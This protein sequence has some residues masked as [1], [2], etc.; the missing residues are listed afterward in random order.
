MKGYFYI[1]LPI[2]L[3]LSVLLTLNVFFQQS[4]Q[5]EV[6]EQFN[7][8]QAFSAEVAASQLKTNL[9]VLSEELEF[10]SSTFAYSTN[11]EAFVKNVLS[12]TDK[13]ALRSDFGTIIDGRLKNYSGQMHQLN[14]SEINTIVTQA[15][16]K[17]SSRVFIV[18]TPISLYLVSKAPQLHKGV[19]FFYR[20]NISDFIKHTFE[21]LKVSNKGYV[22]VIN[23]QGTLLFHPIQPNMV[24]GNI[25]SPDTRCFNCHRDFIFQK[26]LIDSTTAKPDRYE[27]PS[28]Q[29]K[30]IA[31]ARLNY[32]ELSWII[33]FS[34]PYSEVTNTT[35]QSM[36]LYSYLIISI[37]IATCIISVMLIV[38]S[39]RNIEAQELAKRQKALQ[40]YANELEL[41]V[42]QRTAELVS[43]KEKLNT[44]VSAIGCGIIMIDRNA[45]II[46]TNEKMKEIA[47]GDIVGKYCEE[48]LGECLVSSFQKSHDTHTLDT[49]IVT[50]VFEKNRFY[51]ITTA[52]IWSENNELHGY[53]RLVQDITEIKNMENQIVHSEKLS[54]IG[55]LAAGIA[56][57]IGNPLTSIFSFVQILRENE[58]DPLKKENLDIIYNHINRISEI[59]KQLSGFTKMP[60]EHQLNPC[61][62]N[63]VIDSTLNLIQYDKKAKHITL[64]RQL[65]PEL[66]EIV[67]NCNELAQ[68]FL[69]LVL[70]A[71]DAMPDGGTLTATSQFKDNK[72]VLTFEDTGI[73]IAKE[74][75]TRIFDP[76]Y[77]TKEK[78]TGLGLS[79]SYN[80]IKKIGGTISVRSELNKGTAFIIELPVKSQ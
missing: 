46:W 48:V 53:I 12:N 10:V 1:I 17:T 70:N 31:I 15:A 66:P 74:D 62:V 7:I 64:K 14:S 77:T 9:E 22:W 60:T 69:N 29:D 2:A 52:P 54:S 18:Q 43:E 19:L 33:A 26:K 78:G 75:L 35:R 37:F 34:S 51:Q 71:L 57:E 32:K 20:L 16:N 41:R 39:K 61:N 58:D 25:Y 56:H 30:I 47:K 49:M 76:F 6:A 50:N 27:V 68:V 72:V 28:G 13:T 36:Q 73:G 55:R 24:G 4:L 63:D 40:Q 67:A 5:Q 80:I 65:S 3:V 11:F 23:S 45:K 59:L 44:I 21:I 38:F 8:L 42:S 79:V